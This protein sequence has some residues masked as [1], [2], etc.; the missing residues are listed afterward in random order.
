MR[1]LK[2]LAAA[3]AVFMGTQAQSAE[4]PK[5][6]M[7]WVVAP[8]SVATLLAMKPDL[9]IHRDKTYGFEPTHFVSTA[10][11]LVP[12]A[13][14]QLDIV[15]I[16]YSA[17]G[18]AIENAHLTDLRIIADEIQNGIDGHEN[19]SGFLVLKDGP[20]KDFADLKGK[21]VAVLTIGSAT[22]MQARITLRRH[23]LEDKRDY[24]I[25]EAQFPN[26][27]AL[28][29]Q[30]KAAMVAIAPPFAFDPE[31]QAVSR[32]FFTETDAMGPTQLIALA[33]RKPFLDQNHAALVDFM[34]DEIRTVRWF[35]DPN[36][37]DAAVALVSDFNKQPPAQ[38][39]R[40]FTKE[41]NYRDPHAEPNLG[42]LQHSLDLQQEMG[43][44][45]SKI[46]I[47]RYADLSIVHEA[48]VRLK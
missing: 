15:D 44:Q 42:A 25:I 45:R 27:K 22:D 32:M 18:A 4:L 47:Q 14:G 21:V 6:R 5:I 48:A 10:V 36:N 11:E 30:G 43:I 39:Q 23:G 9:S 38:L 26:M 20:I 29:T 46:D 8:G 28:L 3:V 34:E 12:L 33:A 37:H 7:G 31:L 19:G 16:S 35:T 13:S 40:L 2:I 17:I 24:S 41:D 1:S